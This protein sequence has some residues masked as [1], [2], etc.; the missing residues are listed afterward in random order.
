M[1]ELWAWVIPPNVE[2]IKAAAMC[3]ARSHNPAV[4]G[5]MVMCLE[6]EQCKVYFIGSPR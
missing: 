4:E 5:E 6:C 3:A 2:H 1:N